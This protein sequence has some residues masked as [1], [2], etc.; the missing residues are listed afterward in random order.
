MTW[1]HVE[2]IKLSFYGG[3]SITIYIYSIVLSSP[4]DGPSSGTESNLPVSHPTSGIQIVNYRGPQLLY[5]YYIVGPFKKCLARLEL[6][7]ISTVTVEVQVASYH[8]WY[9]RC[10]EIC[11][12]HAG[13]LNNT[14]EEH[15]LGREQADTWP[16]CN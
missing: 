3:H 15:S 12:T 13:S 7:S 4:P 11:P 5:I 16:K 1:L 10:R 9:T 8:T 6:Y 2:S 14:H